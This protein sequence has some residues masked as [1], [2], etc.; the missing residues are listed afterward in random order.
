MKKVVLFGAGQVGAMTVRLLGPEYRVLCIADN[1]PEKCGK[2]LAGI[3]IVSP[4][5][6]LICAP[7]SYCLCVLDPERETQMRAQLETLDFH[8]EIITPASLKTFDARIA[9]MRLIAEQI[10]A[11][12]IPGDVAEL[13]VY[14]GDFARWINAAFPTRRMHLFDTFTGFA[15]QDVIVERENGYSRAQV[16]DFGETA[17][18]F[19][20]KRLFY[21][22]MAVFHKGFFPDTFHSCQT[23]N[24]A[25]VSIDVDLYAPTAA[26][27]PR[28]WDRLAPGGVIM[29]HDYNSMQFCGVKKAVDDFCNERG[30]LP[31]P[32]CDLHGS[33]VIR[34]IEVGKGN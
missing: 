32:V 28:F 11:T 34:K 14:K 22:E 15:E 9:T 16:G 4:E 33:V 25:F 8:G 1:S 10:H 17:K 6:S 13:G 26:A 24:F 2:M 3:P 27:L 5:E 19:V 20:D 18:D 31:L 23:L 29:I 12:G 30:I 7:D 21:R